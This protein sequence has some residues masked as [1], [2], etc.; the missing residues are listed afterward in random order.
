MTKFQS[1]LALREHMLEGHKVS[2]LEALLIFGVQS[3]NAELARLKKDG[4]IIK[5][6]AVSMAKVLRRVNEYASC[7]P[8]S[9]LPFREIVMTEYWISR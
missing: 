3:L 6:E 7:Q 8:P 5:S 9:A 2:L 1:S 4:F